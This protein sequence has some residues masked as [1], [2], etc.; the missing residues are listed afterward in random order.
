MVTQDK[1]TMKAAAAEP[2]IL[3]ERVVIMASMEVIVRWEDTVVLPVEDREQA[4]RQMRHTQEAEEEMR[5][6]E[7]K[8]AVTEIMRDL[9]TAALH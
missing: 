9:P 4:F 1:T 5:L 2:R 6:M 8:V 3:S 7:R